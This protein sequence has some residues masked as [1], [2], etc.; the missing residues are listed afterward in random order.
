MS[1][2]SGVF[3]QGPGDGSYEYIRF[4]GPFTSAVNVGSISIEGLTKSLFETHAVNASNLEIHIAIP[5][6]S[7]GE[8]V[9]IPLN[10]EFNSG[11]PT[12]GCWANRT[13]Q[14]SS[15][16]NFDVAFGGSFKVALLKIKFNESFQTSGI[17]QIQWYTTYQNA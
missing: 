6:N 12:S 3:W 10:T 1:N 16:V 13:D 7:S 11:S 5:G 17:G 15:S 9:W 2:S 14:S 4:F 8:G